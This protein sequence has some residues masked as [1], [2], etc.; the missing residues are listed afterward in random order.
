MRYTILYFFILFIGGCAKTKNSY[1]NNYI[2]PTSSSKASLKIIYKNPDYRN[3]THI[4]FHEDNSCE[5]KSMKIVGS[6]NSKNSRGENKNE[7]DIHLPVNKPIGISARQFH[8]VK[9]EQVQTAFPFK[10]T[11][12][13]P[14]VNFTPKENESYVVEVSHCKAVVYYY[15]EAIASSQAENDCKISTENGEAFQLIK[16]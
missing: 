13:Q 9:A 14:L 11:V 3:N 1:E 4:F 16:K 7:I 15:N 2:E 5:N 8:L 10:L 6:V 12:C